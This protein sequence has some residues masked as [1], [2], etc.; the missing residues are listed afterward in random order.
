MKAVFILDGETGTFK[1]NKEKMGDEKVLENVTFPDWVAYF[2]NSSYVVTDSCH[3]MSFAILYE[4]PFAGI[5][6]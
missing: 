2:K 4:K 6:N 1:K 3:G 5:G